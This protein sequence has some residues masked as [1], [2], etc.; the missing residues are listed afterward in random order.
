[1]VTVGLDGQVRPDQQE[2]KCGQ[3]GE[4]EEEEDDKRAREDADH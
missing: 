4:G 2:V 1:M 3:L